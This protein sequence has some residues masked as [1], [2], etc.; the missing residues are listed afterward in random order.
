MRDSDYPKKKLRC[1]IYTRKSTEAGLEQDFNSLDAHTKRAGPMFKANSMK[2]GHLITR[3]TTMVAIRADRWIGLRFS[4]C[5]QKLKPRR[6]A[7]SSS[8]RST[9]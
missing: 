1:A 5:S 9:D 6:S 8:T 4:S 2:V 7:S 3:S